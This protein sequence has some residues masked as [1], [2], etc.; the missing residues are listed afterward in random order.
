MKK[1]EVRD[2]IYAKLS[3]VLL[4]AG[5]RLNKGEGAFVRKIT[6]G[7]Q[8]IF[9]PLVDYNPIFVFSL[10]IGIRLDAVEDI[11]NRFSGADDKGQKQ[12]LTTITQ[13]TYF[14][15]GRRKDYRVSTPIEIENA[16]SELNT[17]IDSNILP[18]LERYRDIQSLDA[19][20]NTEKLPGFD[21]STL[22]SHAMH[23]I[24]LARL[25]GNNRYNE[26]VIEYD[27]ALK[28]YPPFDRERFARLVSFLN[29]LS[30]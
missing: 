14:T 19:A 21:S 11:F 24:I 23:S 25:A 27:N 3:K 30:P 13:L 5:F 28:G 15:E 20:I 29:D 2:F 26:L 17:V 6:N 12:T 16:F 10:T 7:F 9:V 22:I 8:K 18:F 1:Q 4:S